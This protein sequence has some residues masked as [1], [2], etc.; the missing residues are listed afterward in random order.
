MPIAL[1]LR[2]NGPRDLL[3]HR[4]VRGFS[5]M[6][7]PVCHLRRFGN[8]RSLSIG[9]IALLTSALF[10][11]RA[12]SS[13]RVQTGAEV[14]FSGDLQEL[15][16][17]RVGLVSHQAAHHRDGRATWQTLLDRSGPYQIGAFF[18]PEHGFWGTGR[19]GEKMNRE[20]LVTPRGERIE[21]FSLFGKT[22]R[23][24]PQ[25]LANLDLLLIDLQ[26]IGVRCY[27]FI[28]TLYYVMEEAG[29][30]GLPLMIL[31]RPNPIGGEVIDGPTLE[32]PLRSFIGCAQLP[33]CHGMTIGELARFFNDR[34]DL[35]CQLT[36]IA[37][38]NYNRNMTFAT[39]GLLWVPTSPYIPD[40]S[41]PI[42][43]ATTNL[44]GEFDLI[45]HGVGYTVP[46]RLV[47]A[48]WIDARAFQSR[49]IQASIEGAR[50]IAFQFTPFYG[51]CKDQ[52]CRGLYIDI[53]EAALKRG[54]WRPFLHQMKLALALKALRPD[55]FANAIQMRLK[56]RL[57]FDKC[58]GTLQ[59][60]DA[61]SSPHPNAVPALLKRIESDVSQFRKL[62]KPYLIDAYGKSAC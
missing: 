19:A 18:G 26:D 35:K 6:S 62:R 8:Y 37:M 21:I 3:S 44:L 7:K 61:L 39:T 36:I 10:P 43:Y 24:T 55:L 41:T 4:E 22:R 31:D 57:Y 14:L 25:M 20:E 46:F 16:G 1:N 33:F 13:P 58:C 52:I 32:M 38:R 59:V 40:E 42:Y 54:S 50:H 9:I 51:K 23:P 47:G 34:Y 45:N 2:A 48:P 11:C 17:K 29:K 15:R 56:D 30:I 28:S 53:D 49:M 27:T 60:L 5:T 12:F